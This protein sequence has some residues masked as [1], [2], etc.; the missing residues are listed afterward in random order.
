MDSL[1]ELKQALR[2]VNDESRTV[3]IAKP[4][5]QISKSARG[6]IYRGVSKNGRKWQVRLRQNVKS[7]TKSYYFVRFNY[8]R[9]CTK[10]TKA[11]LFQRNRPLAFTTAEQF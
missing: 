1:E 2:Q 4:K 11:R 6:S 7:E 9:K 10:D 3:L 5:S 8:C